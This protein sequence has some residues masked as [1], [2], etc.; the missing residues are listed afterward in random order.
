MKEISSSGEPKSNE[1]REVGAWFGK[2]T[3]DATPD[4]EVDWADLAARASIEG[5]GSPARSNVS[6]GSA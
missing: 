2:S 3:A 1:D 5:R 6:R 4:A